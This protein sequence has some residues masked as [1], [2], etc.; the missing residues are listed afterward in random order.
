MQILEHQCP[1]CRTRLR[2][3]GPLRESHEFDCPDC[4]QPLCLQTRHGDNTLVARERSRALQTAADRKPAPAGSRHGNTP[5]IVAWTV[6]GAILLAFMIYLFSGETQATSGS[7]ESP[8]RSATANAPPAIPSDQESAQTSVADSAVPATNP[9]PDT[10][11]NTTPAASTLVN[12]DSPPP[13]EP[14][15]PAGTEIA[16]AAID[17]TPQATDTP[18]SSPNAAAAVEPSNAE[19]E[20]AAAR[21]REAITAIRDRMDVRLV[22]YQT[23]KPVPLR[24]FLDELSKLT[25]TWINTQTAGDQLDTLVSVSM[26]NCSARDV[27]TAGLEQAGYTWHV[28]AN[29]IHLKQP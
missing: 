23:S 17:E 4:A 16:Q 6:S 25:A 1:R 2:L 27:L 9:P 10:A 11:E 14:S 5:K 26:E 7:A 13:D 20:L 15:E 22:R 3:R 29:G 18:R 28:L 19:A 24:A 12:I 21:E 8:D